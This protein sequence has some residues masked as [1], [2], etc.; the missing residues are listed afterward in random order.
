MDL[1]LIICVMVMRI[2][3]I[4]YRQAFL[5]CINTKEIQNY[6]G[7][8]Y[9]LAIFEEIL[10]KSSCEHSKLLKDKTKVTEGGEKTLQ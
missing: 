10:L 8:K 5:T 2:Q 1:A 4:E 7:G 3:K 9:I 6:A